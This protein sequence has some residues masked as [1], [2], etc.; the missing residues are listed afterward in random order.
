LKSVSVAVD[1]AEVEAFVDGLRV[2]G[3]RVAVSTARGCLHDLP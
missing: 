1:A 3:E 2:G